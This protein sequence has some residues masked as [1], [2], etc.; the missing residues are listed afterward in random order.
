MQENPLEK[1][2]KLMKSAT[3]VNVGGTVGF[4]VLAFISAALQIR[5]LLISFVL[6]AVLCAAVAFVLM[7]RAV[8]QNKVAVDAFV[9]EAKAAQ[10]RRMNG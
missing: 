7:L 5:A 1:P 9:Q 3:W 10:Q 2:L 8:R 6:L 4:L